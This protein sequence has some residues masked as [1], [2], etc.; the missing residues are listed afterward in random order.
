VILFL[1]RL[2]LTNYW[3]FEFL[4]FRQK[5]K[6]AEQFGKEIGEIFPIFSKPETAFRLKFHYPEKSSKN[7]LSW[8]MREVF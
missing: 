5:W 4:K 1:L 3:S 6:T 8:K 2:S 7:N